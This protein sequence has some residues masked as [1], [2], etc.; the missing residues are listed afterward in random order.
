MAYYEEWDGKI[1]LTAFGKHLNDD[2]VRIERFGITIS[3]KDKLQFY[4]EQMYTSNHFD[5]KEMME[6]ENKIITIKDDFNEAKMYFEGLIKDYEVYVQKSSS[7]AGKHKFQS[8]NQ[9]AEAHCG[10]KLRQYIAG[11]AQAAVAQE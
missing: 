5:K 10:N 2:Q 8:A 3:D 4:L 11:I 6:W 7:T 9:A 1:H